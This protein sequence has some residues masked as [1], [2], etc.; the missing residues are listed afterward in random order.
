MIQRHGG[1]GGGETAEADGQQAETSAWKG[2]IRH[3]QCV[4]GIC[5]MEAGQG[6]I[7]YMIHDT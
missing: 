7:I 4:G 1:G 5:C 2:A 3:V 6:Q